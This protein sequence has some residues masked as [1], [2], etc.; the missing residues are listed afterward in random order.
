MPSIHTVEQFIA[1]VEAGHGVEAMIRFY[2]EHAS[3]QEND[4]VPR[5]GKKAL[6]D[7]ERAAQAAVTELKS[8]CVRPI[9]ISG[10]FAVIRW[11]FEYQTGGGRKIRFEELARQRWQ[12]NLIVEEKF[13]YDPGQFK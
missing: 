4:G 13:Y 6:L 11:V 2:A 9:F 12:G 7:F 3:M 10:E 1:M 5:V 8:T